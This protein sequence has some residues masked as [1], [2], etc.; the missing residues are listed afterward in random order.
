MFPSRY[1][2]TVTVLL[3]ALLLASPI[4]AASES[5][6]ASGWSVNNNADWTPFPPNPAPLGAPNNSCTGAS[7]PTGSW[8]EF[9]FGNFSIPAGDLVTGIQVRAK[10]LA[11]TAPNP[12]QLQ[13]SGSN[14]GSSQSL[15]IATGSAA[16]SST[17]FVSVGGDG[18]L[19]GTS[20][21]RSDFNNGNVGLR[22]TQASNTVDLDAI[23]LTVFF[24]S[25]SNQAPDAVCQ[26]VTV[27]AD[28]SC[29]ANVT[30]AQVDNG[31]SDPDSDP[32]TFSLSPAG[33][34]GKGVTNVTLT[35]SDGSLQ[36]TCNATITV[37]DNTDPVISLTGLPS[38]TLECGVDTY[39][40]QGATATD[41]CD[42][43]VMVTISGDTVDP[44]T[45]GVYEVTYNAVDDD[46]NAAAEVK[47]TVTVQDTT[48]PVI[49]LNGPAS[50]TL[51]CGVDTYTEQGATA[52]D[53]C[54][55]SVDVII[56]GDTVD[57]GTPGVYVV[58]YDAVD[59]SGNAA[60]RVT[61]AVTV[62]DTTPP[63]I[64]C[65]APPTI[66]PP[67]APISF[68]A[69][70]EDACVGAVVPEVTSFDC[71]WV[72]P[73]GKLVDKTNSCEVN[74]SGDTVTILDSG[75][76]KDTIEWTVSASD[77]NG[78][79]S[80]ETCSVTVVNPGKGKN[81]QLADDL[82]SEYEFEFPL[83]GEQV[84]PA[85]GS[86]AV[87]FCRG[88]INAAR[89]EMTL[90]CSH[91]LRAATSRL[92]EAPAGENGR[93]LDE[94]HQLGGSWEQTIRLT[95]DQVDELH[96]GQFYLTVTSER[97]PEGEIRGQIPALP[98]ILD[99]AQFG[100]GDGFS[101]HLT[102]QNPHETET[103]S[104]RLRFLDSGGRPL[105]L[106]L[107]ADGPEKGALSGSEIDF[108]VP[109]LGEQRYSVQAAGRTRTGSS[110]VIS[111]GEV[112]A[113]VRYQLEDV[114]TAS[115]VG[116]RP[117]DGALIPV[118]HG[119]DI[120][121]GVAILN[122]DRHE[123]E[124]DFSLHDRSGKEIANGRAARLL[125]PGERLAVFFQELFPEARFD[126][127]RGE[128]VIRTQS[129]SFSVIAMEVDSRASEVDTLPVTPLRRD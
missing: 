105:V 72:N 104:G 1:A 19:W 8:A 125:Q 88:Q 91:N 101:S 45:P 126:H 97:F 58:T 124:L 68:T 95:P 106:E 30:A 56:G 66:T 32:L 24:A 122:S 108:T 76:V 89:T 74:F 121:T 46:G 111:D 65:N 93:L 21:T 33:P 82:P 99:F 29:Q 34:Y 43:S 6:F 128:L 81:A 90:G 35:V 77:G 26:N 115:A 112:A 86:A 7:T 50:I 48:A 18:D 119:P 73:S 9:T 28:N 85:T 15:P 100:S 52:S 2:L 79:T 62:Q 38:L 94:S 17:V 117:L 16:C 116:S 109:P 47:R 37:E 70:A 120:E 84:V 92:Q 40:E 53:A 129:G 59:D 54:D 63:V 41:N 102:L 49:T 123:I 3:V 4:F 22:L 83:D 31:S 87:G 61:R 78:N 13:L 23:E 14:V 57:P 110:R 60:T 27:D 107:T 80:T 51:E 64:Q 39:T 96:A 118:E 67:D 25:G 20:L 12:V 11:Q 44:A 103:V 127:F 5:R 114:G 71:F 10:Y 113:T 98:R 55:P 69:M 42:P 36:D 75:G